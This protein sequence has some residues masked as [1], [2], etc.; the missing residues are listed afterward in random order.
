MGV[1]AAC[2]IFKSAQ[3]LI[4]VY[5]VAVIGGF[6]VAATEAVNLTMIAALSL[7]HT[8]YMCDS[9]SH[10]GHYDSK[11]R[12]LEVITQLGKPTVK[13]AF[14]TIVF[15]VVMLFPSNDLHPKFAFFALVSSLFSLLHSMI[16]FPALLACVGP[17][18]LDGNVYFMLETT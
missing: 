6:D 3:I 16:F 9:Y 11:S 15:A 12:V 5:A 17:N 7:R 18:G 2:A 4:A 10:S 1:L 13:A 14:G 8:L